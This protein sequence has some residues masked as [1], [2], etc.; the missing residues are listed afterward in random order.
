MIRP[1]PTVCGLPKRLEERRNVNPMPLSA[2]IGLKSRA[3]LELA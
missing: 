2:E 1:H 3:K